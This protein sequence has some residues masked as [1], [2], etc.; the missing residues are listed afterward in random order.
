MILIFLV[1]W[2]CDRGCAQLHRVYFKTHAEALGFIEALER[3]EAHE[4]WLWRYKMPRNKEAMVAALN[5]AVG[6]NIELKGGIE[7]LCHL[8]RT[9]QIEPGE[10]VTVH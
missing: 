10:A 1:G 6:H 3:N 4:I 8:K 5:E 9:D 2:Y 7:Q